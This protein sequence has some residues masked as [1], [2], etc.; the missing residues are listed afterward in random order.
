MNSERQKADHLAL[1]KRRYIQDKKQNNEHRKLIVEETP[2]PNPITLIILLK[3][4][5]EKKSANK[6]NG[7]AKYDR[8]AGDAI[9]GTSEN[10]WKVTFYV[11]VVI[12]LTCSFNFLRSRLSIPRENPR[13]AEYAMCM[14]K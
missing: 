10:V 12:C 8:R 7:N 14:S 5:V 13:I 3:K 6:N 4:E 9:F 2:S 1:A 11:I